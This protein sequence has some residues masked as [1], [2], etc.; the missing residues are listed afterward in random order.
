MIYTPYI[1]PLIFAILIDAVLAIYAIRYREAPA[2]Q[3]LQALMWASAL[4]AFLYMG[5][6]SYT[7]ISAKIFLSQLR[8]IPAGAIAPTALVLVLEYLGIAEWLSRPCLLAIYLI[9]AISAL[10]SLTGAY[11]NLFRYA[12]R[13]HADSPVAG[14]IFQRG[15][16]WFVYYSY[17][18]IVIAIACVLLV[19][20]LRGGTASR[21]P[22]R[23][24]LLI[25]LAILSSMIVD[26]LYVIGL[27]PV[28][29]YYWTPAVF[30]LTGWLLCVA[31]FSGHMF[32]FTPV[33]RNTLVENM[34]GLV[35]VLDN[36]RR[37]VDFNR[38]AEAACGLSKAAI[39]QLPEQTL[40]AEWAAVLGTGD[41]AQAVS[42]R[43]GQ[44][45]SLSYKEQRV[46]EV[47]RTAIQDRRGR[48]LSH[49]FMF[50]DITARTHLEEALR[51]AHDLLEQ[52]VLE[53]TTELAEANRLLQQEM[54]EHEKANAARL[55]SEERYRLLFE[56]S[57]DAI[58]LTAPDGR[59]FAANPSACRTFGWSEQEMIQLG[60]E[61]IIDLSDPRL[62]PA[63]E[64]RRQTGKFTGE[65]TYRCKDG[66]TFPGEVT[67][68]IFTDRNGELRTSMIVRDVTERKRSEQ[69]LWESEQ[70]YRR[71]VEIAHEGIVILDAQQRVS[72][73]NPQVT[74]M[75]G[76]QPEQVIGQPGIG[77]VFQEDLAEQENI[78]NERA[79]GRAGRYERKMRHADG[80]TVWFAISS[81][82]L[83]DEDGEFT[84]SFSM[85]SDI[86]ERKLAEEALR[87]ANAYNR[88]LIEASLDPFVAIGR[89]NKIID[90]NAATE[91]ATGFDR[92]ELIGTYYSAYFN[93]R[94][95]AHQVFHRALSEGSV[96]DCELELKH[97]DGRST[98]VLFNAS[99]Y[100]DESG[101]VGGLFAAARD[102]TRRKQIE[103][104]EREQRQLAEALR[105]SSMALT[106]SLNLGQVLDQVIASVG[107][108]VPSD[109]VSLLLVENGAPGNPML[110]FARYRGYASDGTGDSVLEM[111][112]ALEQVPNFR[113]MAETGKSLVIEDVTHYPGWVDFPQGRW[114]R[115]I[116]GTPV[117]IKDETIGF[118]DLASATPAFFN[119]EHA[120][121]LEAFAA[122]AAI[123]IENA[124]LY[125]EVLAARERL[126]AISVR[127][128]QVQESERRHLAR[129][130]H[131]EIGQALT[132]LKFSL[133]IGTGHLDSATGQ[134]AALR[135]RLRQARTQVS[136]LIVKRASF[137][138]RCA[139]LCW[140][141]WDCCR[142]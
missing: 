81:S 117:R 9:P 128:V 43:V 40:G 32:D 113:W 68:S 141:T 49:L 62:A 26:V 127:L 98:A 42:L 45:D 134:P 30:A 28:H 44:A 107:S 64:I 138:W 31:V 99:L 121:R 74:Q 67:S 82:P 116:V 2:A 104:A 4:T 25:L 129:E 20:A 6:I 75:V 119:A 54:S 135:A 109:S 55:E 34:A 21:P 48:Q 114:I 126:Q 1:W 22:R 130:L 120:R 80:H 23:N 51:Q 89:D 8:F 101:Q 36:Q 142:P 72:Y 83:I 41:V 70:K 92:Q 102:I 125:E 19:A 95:L 57:L 132:G 10:F 78:L 94:E 93:D 136:E 84:G 111:R 16:W 71:L 86:T 91:Q 13:I 77:F 24:S 35:I 17:T 5:E 123:A 66:E 76:Y 122:Q 105:D 58:L 133:E 90:A 61:G 38:A 85:L 39:G 18:L 100:R 106:R 110:K 115:S 65:L 108:V 73:I 52:R 112:F 53:R 60:R 46:Y 79:Q 118:L 140:M 7:A 37:I 139:R 47:T 27:T 131:D 59:I 87:Q 103:A 124:R 12:F 56:N 96:R 33:A 88:S 15:A 69:A 11:H 14:L 50:Q 63:L 97:R 3:P 137:R 29:G